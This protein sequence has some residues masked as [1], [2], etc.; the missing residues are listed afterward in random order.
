VNFLVKPKLWRGV[1]PTIYQDQ[2]PFATTIREDLVEL[3]EELLGEYRSDQ[4]I[5]VYGSIY[6]L[7]EFYRI[8]EIVER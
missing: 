5:V 4:L 7:G 8:G 6:L 3:I 1:D 2:L